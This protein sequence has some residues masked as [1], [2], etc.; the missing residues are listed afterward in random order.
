[1]LRLGVAPSKPTRK[2]R[3]VELSPEQY[4]LMQT[5]SGQSA[6][7]MLNTLTKQPGWQDVPDGVKKDAM[8]D[9]F[10]Q[11]SDVGRAAVFMQFPELGDAIAQKQMEA[12]Q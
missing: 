7:Q 6:R 10:R 5:A 2:I 11:A 8:L 9:V 3:D 1:M 4:D 12:V